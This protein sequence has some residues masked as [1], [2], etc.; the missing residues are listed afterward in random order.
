MSPVSNGQIKSLRFFPGT[1]GFPH[2]LIFPLVSQRSD[3]NVL[4]RKDVSAFVQLHFFV[5]SHVI[6]YDVDVLGRGFVIAHSL[7]DAVSSELRTREEVDD[8]IDGVEV[9]DEGVGD[10]FAEGVDARAEEFELEAIVR[11]EAVG[12]AGIRRGGGR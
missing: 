10:S 5:E 3:D 4:M 11:G 8:V 9:V 12:G 2:A 7:E 6:R 1:F